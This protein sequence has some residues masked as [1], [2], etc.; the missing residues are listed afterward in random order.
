[1]RKNLNI[2]GLFILFFT[3]SCA[4]LPYWENQK[5][6]QINKEDGYATMI[7]YDSAVKVMQDESSSSKY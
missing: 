2:F 4:S 7:P 5:I 6:T 3:F 1:M